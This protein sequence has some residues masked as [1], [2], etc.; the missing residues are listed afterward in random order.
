MAKFL[1]I[2]RESTASRAQPSAKE[3]QALARLGTLGCKSSVRRL[4]PWAT[5]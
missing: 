3:M 2:Y 5:D 4:C 1:F